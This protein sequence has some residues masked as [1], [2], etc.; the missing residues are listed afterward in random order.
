VEAAKSELAKLKEIADRSF[1]ISQ[2]NSELVTRKCALEVSNN[3]KDKVI[4]E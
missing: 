4:A 2:N 1:K 3:Q